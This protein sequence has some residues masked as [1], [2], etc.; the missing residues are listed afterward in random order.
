MEDLFYKYGKLTRCDVKRGTA[1][2]PPLMFLQ[3]HPSLTFTFGAGYGF[4][5]YEDRRD[6]QDALR[7]LDGVSV[8]GTRIAIEWAKGARRTGTRPY[9][10][11]QIQ[12]LIECTPHRI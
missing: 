11:P 5:E 6:A 1:V 3:F 10:L 9:P 7:D 8:L 12:I 4:V 2:P